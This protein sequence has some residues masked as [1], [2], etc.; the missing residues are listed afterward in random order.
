V[1]YS[2]IKVD[3]PKALRQT[4]GM[5]RRRNRDAQRPRRFSGFEAGSTNR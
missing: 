2:E 1:R 4:A 3:I 5:H